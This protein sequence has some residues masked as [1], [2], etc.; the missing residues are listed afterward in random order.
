MH[1]YA[2]EKCKEVSR[3]I[4]ETWMWLEREGMLAPNPG[5]STGSWMFVTRKGFRLRQKV[6]LE[7]YKKS[8]F[9][10]KNNLDKNLTVKVYPL[11]IRGDYDTAVFQAYKEVEVRVRKKAKYSDDLIGVKL[12]RTA[13]HPEDGPL[14]NSEANSSERQ[15]MS[16]LFSG[17]VGLF[18]NP[19]SHREVNLNN[20]SEAAEIILFANYLLR[21]IDR[22]KINSA[23]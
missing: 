9:L 4:M 3:V 19:S 16:D 6:D 1:P 17:S 20:P 13:F 8:R 7:A 5:E 23:I 22:C 18:K 12:M 11:F 14:R 2:G 21:L 15:A 10:P